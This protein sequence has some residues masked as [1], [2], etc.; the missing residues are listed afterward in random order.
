MGCSSDSIHA[1]ASTSDTFMRSIS[2][3]P[4]D[5]GSQA[6][7]A[8]RTARTASLSVVVT[9]TTLTLAML[10]ECR[11][12]LGKHYYRQSYIQHIYWFRLVFL[13]VNTT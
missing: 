9:K 4:K 1:Y 12:W 13:S 5:R 2:D 8:A 6:S 7:L 3:Y 11:V 10:C